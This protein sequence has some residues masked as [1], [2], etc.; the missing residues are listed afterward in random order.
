VWTLAAAAVTAL[1]IRIAVA[2]AFF[3]DA[4][5]TRFAVSAVTVVIGAGA[6]L[7][8]IRALRSRVRVFPDRL[9]AT[10][11]LGRRH[12]ILPGEITSIEP[13]WS[14]HVGVRGV[15]EGG[16]KSF[17][18]RR[19]DRHYEDLA[20]WLGVNAT[21]PWTAYQDLLGKLTHQERP[22][23]VRDALS[24]LAL[25]VFLGPA[26]ALLPA[27][28]S[29]TAYDDAH[30]QDLTCSVTSAEG[31]TVSSRS[32]RGIGSSRPAVAFVTNDCGRMTLKRGVDGDSRDDIAR[33][34]DRAPGEY[35]FEVGSGSLW[36]RQHVSWL[37]ISPEVYVVRPSP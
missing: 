9:E 5:L 8:G 2:T 19:F 34:Y 23:V 30:H 37:R 16:R 10:F 32:T 3:G 31:V 18:V 22:R 24:S 25:I 7:L 14:G 28:L 33:R 29:L 35:V 13:L 4:H 12:V 1:G 20:D 21:G 15:T 36:L 17:V 6:V 26:L 11:G 27:L